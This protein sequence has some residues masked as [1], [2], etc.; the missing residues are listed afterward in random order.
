V[1]QLASCPVVSKISSRHMW[2]TWLLILW[3]PRSLQCI[4]DSLG[5][6]SCGYEDLVEAPVIHLASYPMDTKISSVYLSPTWPSCS[7]DTKIS[8]LH[9]WPTWLPILCIPKSLQYIC[10][11]VGLLYCGYK[12]I[13]KAPVI[14]LASYPVDT[15]ISSL[16][17]SSHSFPSAGYK[18]L[19]SISCLLGFPFCEY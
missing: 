15:K 1:T 17:C 18:N 16:H 4:C 6:L 10:D 8:S 7:L 19:F 13:F 12:D 14:Y 3:I 2:F 5:L 9:P 11:P